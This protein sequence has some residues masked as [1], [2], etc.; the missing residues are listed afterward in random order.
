MGR[1]ASGFFF[2]LLLAWIFT[3][4]TALAADPASCNL[5][6]V[7]EAPARI[8]GGNLV[9]DVQIGGQTVRMK[10]GTRQRFSLISP[11]LVTQLKLRPRAMTG[12]RVADDAGAKISYM[13]SAPDVTIG[14][15]KATDTPFLIQAENGG[16]P[17][18]WDGVIA[19]DILSRY[20]VVQA[21][22]DRRHHDL[23]CQL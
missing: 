12:D 18:A 2:G 14:T 9:V 15:L 4:A 23:P 19:A 13:V 22:Q 7:T 3:T 6:R 5:T 8:E 16:A 17:L 10:I 11:E 21:G 1:Y 20:D